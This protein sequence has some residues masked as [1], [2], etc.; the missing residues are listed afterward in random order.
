MKVG[1]ENVAPAEIEAHLTGHPSVVLAQVVGRPDE[2]YTEVPVAF[3]Q[4]V[5]GMEATEEELIE[6]CKGEIASFK[7]PRAV[8]FI[9]AWPMSATKIQKYKLREIAAGS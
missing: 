1:G 9:D 2:K 5:E 3:V 6:Y 4:L 8:H 7:I